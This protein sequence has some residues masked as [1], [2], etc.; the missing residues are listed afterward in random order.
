MGVM[1]PPCRQ[2]WFNA[3]LQN[4]SRAGPSIKTTRQIA[5][6]GITREWQQLHY[7]RSHISHLT[8]D[9]SPVVTRAKWAAVTGSNTGL[10]ISHKLADTSCLNES[11]QK[12]VCWCWYESW[13]MSLMTPLVSSS[14]VVTGSICPA[15]SIVP[16]G[17]SVSYR[18]SIWP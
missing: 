13:V 8:I 10:I 3:S 1:S 7:Y 2:Y 12:S 9:N 15:Q 4:R 18:L 14:H 17:S 5:P 6:P 11:T 16:H